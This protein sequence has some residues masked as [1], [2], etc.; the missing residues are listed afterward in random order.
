M[1]VNQK[2]QFLDVLCDYSLD[3]K[4]DFLD[5]DPLVG[6]AFDLIRP[7]ID[8]NNSRFE[9]GKKGGRPKPNDNQ[10]ITKDK[11]NYNQE[12][13][14]NEKPHNLTPSNDKDVSVSV[15]KDV[16]KDKDQETIVEAIASTQ[17]IDHN[18]FLKIWNDNLNPKVLS[19]SKSRIDK[20]SARIKTDKEF[21]KHFEVCVSKIKSSKFLLGDNKNSWKATFDWVIE[22]DKNYLKILEGNYDKQDKNQYDI[23]EEFIKRTGG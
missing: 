7:L 6:T 1:N 13:T 10:T 5:L 3:D 17:R 18:F 19:L 23:L 14:N 11:P 4:K 22:N 9:N 12:T 15:D 21:D 16:N 20:L 2:A 8:K